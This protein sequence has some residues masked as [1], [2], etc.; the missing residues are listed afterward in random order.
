MTEKERQL[1][2]LPGYFEYRARIAECIAKEEECQS[3]KKTGVELENCIFEYPVVQ[4]GVIRGVVASRCSR[5]EQFFAMQRLHTAVGAARIGDKYAGC[6]FGS[7]K[8]TKDGV[9]ALLRCVEYAKKWPNHGGKGILLYG[10]YGTGKTHL[11]VATLRNV[12]ESGGTGIFIM[13][14]D[15]L[16]SLRS[17]FDKQRGQREASI[18]EEIRRAPFL[19]MDDLGSEKRTDWVE[20]RIFMI[21]NYRYANSLPTV[22][23][24]NCEPEKLIEQ[25]GGRTVSRIM[26][27]CAQCKMDGS[28]YR[29]KLQIV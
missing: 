26:E 21:I 7:F 15:M 24:T 5:Q 28:D 14:P 23:T 13:V 16:D 20:E 18:I 12:I 2:I 17:E 25:I 8:Q 11:A 1:S 10:P 6:S 9:N 22:I 27:M 4:D 29:L 19:V 3:C